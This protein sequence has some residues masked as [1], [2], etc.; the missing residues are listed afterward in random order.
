VTNFR[1]LHC[2]DILSH[3]PAQVY[4]KTWD[5]G[6]ARSSSHVAQTQKK[7]LMKLERYKWTLEGHEGKNG[8][9]TT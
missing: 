9:F 1:H 5:I 7:T 6:V 8:V 4:N 2:V 3:I